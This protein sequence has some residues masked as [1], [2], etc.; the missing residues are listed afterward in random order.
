EKQLDRFNKEIK[1]LKALD[2]VVNDELR[3]REDTSKIHNENLKLKYQLHHLKKS[4]DEAHKERHKYTPSILFVLQQFFTRAIHDAYPNIEESLEASIQNCGSQS[5]F[6]DYQCNSAMSLYKVMKSKQNMKKKKISDPKMIAEQLTRNLLQAQKNYMIDLLT[7]APPAFINITLAKTP[8]IDILT[9][10]LKEGSILPPNPGPKYKVIVDLSSPNLAKEMHVGHLRSTIIGDSLCRLLEYLGFDVLR[11]N[12]VGDWG[13]QF[14]MLIA[15]L[16]EKFPDYLK[17]SP[18]IGDLQC[19]YKE[20]KVRFDNDPEFKK[21]AYE[22]VVK[23]QGREDNIMAAWKLICDESIREFQAIYDLLDIKLVYRGES[24][25]QDMMK[26]MILELQSQNKL[27]NE[28]GRLV[29]FVKNHDVPLILQKSDGGFTYDTSDLASIRHR[30]QEEKGQRLIYVVDSGQSLHFNALFGACKELGWASNVKLE[31][32]AFGVVLGEDKKKFKTR[33]GD[34]I[35]LLDLISEGLKR[36]EAKLIEKGRD[37]VLTPAEFEAAKNAVALSCIKYADLSNNRTKDYIFSFDKMLDD[38]GNTAAYLLYA[39]T[40]IRSIGRLAGHDR[41]TLR[42][43]MLSLETNATPTNNTFGGFKLEHEKELKL[44]KILCRIGEIILQVTD[45]LLIHTLCD[46]LY[47]VSCVFTEFYDNCYCV[48]KDKAGN[49]VKVSIERLMIC[50][51]TALV[52][53]L[54]FKILGIVPVERM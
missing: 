51:I 53:E 42:K 45:T 38:R 25:Y 15:H 40:R 23:L 32:A 18:S 35:R 31:H 11:L 26:G 5:T 28:D 7:I 34:T 43:M 29:M 30:I 27:V 24:F 21:R 22:N 19:F 16:Q 36:T 52:M 37:K 48:E 47:E 10:F 2:Q 46:Y 14:G 50:E 1:E 3:Q 33:S 6:G 13:T 39:Y 49:I 20:S 4:L 44:A 17:I 41:N 9:N 12:H 54:C 8:I